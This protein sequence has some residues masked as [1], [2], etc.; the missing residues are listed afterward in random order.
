MVSECELCHCG[1]LDHWAWCEKAPVEEFDDW[2]C[3][4]CGVSA[5]TVEYRDCW[6]NMKYCH[7]SDYYWC[8]SCDET[9]SDCI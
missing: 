1:G 7:C 5:G 4:I 3:P 6:G 9:S 8:T 2:V